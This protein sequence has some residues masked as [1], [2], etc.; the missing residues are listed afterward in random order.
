MKR[1]D[2]SG[3]VPL[4]SFSVKVFGREKTHVA[5]LWAV[6]FGNCNNDQSE[7]LVVL[8]MNGG[9]ALQFSKNFL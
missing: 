6:T 9:D 5:F 1:F 2:G 3:N 4:G 7:A 8:I